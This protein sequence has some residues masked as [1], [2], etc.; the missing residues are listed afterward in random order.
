MSSFNLGFV[1]SLKQLLWGND[2]G[3]GR[4]AEKFVNKKRHSAK[5]TTVASKL[6]LP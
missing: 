2:L 1:V 6:R 5:S 3:G 4:S